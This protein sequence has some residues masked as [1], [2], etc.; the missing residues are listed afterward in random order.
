MTVVM[1]VDMDAF[2]AAVEMR[3]RPELQAVPMW[4]GGQVRGVVLS[5]NYSA[6]A[7]GVRGG[8]AVA[9]A[10]RL[11][12]HGVG[13]T[14][15]FADYSRVSAGVAA[16]L[17]S[18]A[19][20][21][22]MASIDEAYLELP[23]GSGQSAVDLGHLVRAMVYDEQAITCSV[24]IG[25]N[26]LIAK[27]ASVSAK[28]DGLVQVGAADV[29]AFLHPLPVERLVGVGDSTAARLHRLGVVTIGDLAHCSRVA[30]RQGF[31]P[32]AGAILAELAWG[33]D[34]G[35]QWA[36]PGERGMGCQET[37]AADLLEPAEVKAEILR[38]SDTVATRMRAAGVMGRTVTLSLRFADFT[39]RS[40]S[41]ALGLPTD[42]TTQVYQ[43]ALRL[44]SRMVGKRAVV[45][46]VGVRVTG[47]VER[48]R[49][50]R[51]PTLD[52]GE[53][54]WE[55]AEVAADGL[56]K[57]FGPRSVQRAVLAGRKR[58]VSI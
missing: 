53:R 13:V 4:V 15:D 32:H 44:H 3:R 37:F 40:R 27:M 23:A 34:G 16:I 52:E 12:P 10:R 54:D 49:V 38:V 26:R 30:L 29:V 45:R 36:R 9:Q 11:C 28:P 48:S 35:R 39:T 41:L 58:G 14:P 20:R 47:L 1:H 42:S 2:Y 55:A 33:R 7:F 51:Q 31:G 6:R 19:A 43:A 25:P 57:A 24:G 50:W 22:E 56:N 46:R 5:A 21:V 18:V 8:M 17:R